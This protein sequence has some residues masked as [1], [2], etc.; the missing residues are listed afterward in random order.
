MTPVVL[1]PAIEPVTPSIDAGD[2][3]RCGLTMVE[4]AL[5]GRCPN[6]DIADLFARVGHQLLAAAR[7]RAVMVPR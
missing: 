5:A 6:A 3:L 4:L 2:A 1:V 7:V